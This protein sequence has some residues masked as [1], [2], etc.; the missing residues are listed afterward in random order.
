M[1]TGRINSFLSMSGVDGPGIRCVVFMQGCPLRC[2]Y[3]HN[4]DTWEIDTG[5]EVTAD[6][7][8]ERV[9]RYKDYFGARG[10]V[11][12]SGGEALIQAEFA[13]EFF[14][15]CKRRGINTALDTAGIVINE[16]V[17][18]TLDNTDLCML[19]IKMTDEESYKKHTGA[20]LSKVLDFLDVLQK[21]GVRTWVRQV[22]VPGIN[23][24]A[25]QVKKLKELCDRYPCIEKTELLPFR[26]LCS[27][28]YE[29][30]KL[31]FPLRDTPEASPELIYELSEH[32]K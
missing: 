6:A 20:S 12:L 7:L 13:A 11:T 16:A 19:D 31:E 32:L 25:G 15:R 8:T 26:K 17:L 23:D 3:C 2:A 14:E 1:I 29:E 9:L 24:T 21:K 22:I 28:K 30:M 4:P 10:G 5:E 18:K 27:S